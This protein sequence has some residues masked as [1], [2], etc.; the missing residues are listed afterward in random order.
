[1]DYYLPTVSSLLR[2]NSYQPTWANQATVMSKSE[3][4]EREQNLNKLHERAQAILSG[5]AKSK[6]KED[7]I[8]ELEGIIRQFETQFEGLKL[9]MSTM[10]KADQ[11]KWKPKRKAFNE[12][13]V[14]LKTD[15][16]WANNA[17][18]KD[19][20]LGADRQ[21]EP[22]DRNNADSLIGHGVGVLQDGKDSLNRTLQVVVETKAIGIQT[23]T[24]LQEQTKQIE[25][26]DRD[27]D[28]ME[29]TIKKSSRLI[30]QIARKVATDKYVM[31]LTGLVVIAILAI[32]GMSLK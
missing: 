27:L 13:L 31:V 2:P 1:V 21:R 19:Q 7:E 11:T 12:Q 10:K 16:Q 15:L 3:I 26:M 25:R 22:V 4:E 30:R 24:Q 29:T 28:E 5:L 18:T 32:I 17:H 20:L 6:K 8:R 23:A 14:Q 9:E